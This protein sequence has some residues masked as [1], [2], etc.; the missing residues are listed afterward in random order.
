MKGLTKIEPTIIIV[1]SRASGIK[2]EPEKCIQY[3]SKRGYT[4]MYDSGLNHIYTN[5]VMKLQK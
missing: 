5:S 4:L 1:E 3:F 2:E